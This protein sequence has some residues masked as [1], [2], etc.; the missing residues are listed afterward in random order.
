MLWRCPVQRNTWWAR[1]GEITIL[2]LLLLTVSLNSPP[3]HMYCISWS[4][5]VSMCRRAIKE[6]LE[7][8]FVPLEATMP[9]TFHSKEQVEILTWADEFGSLFFH[10]D[11]DWILSVLMQMFCNALDDNINSFV[12]LLSHIS[13]LNTYRRCHALW[14]MPTTSK[15]LHQMNMLHIEVEY[16]AYSV[17]ADVAS[18]ISCLLY[19][20]YHVY[21]L[22]YV[23]VLR[24][25][26]L[27][28]L[29][30]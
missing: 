2:F 20:S 13:T 16:A 28:F 21:V 4:S 7:I 3:L 30:M 9:L 19:M 8:G 17:L 15:Y 25:I 29:A 26:V 24:C 11:S 5:F 12:V 23:V 10:L 22:L 14:N 18:G 1:A 6:Y 27:Y